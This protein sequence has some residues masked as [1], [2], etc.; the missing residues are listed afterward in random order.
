VSIQEKTFDNLISSIEKCKE[1][2]F[3][4]VLFS[5]GIRYIG[6]TTAKILAKAFGNI[7]NL[8]NATAEELLKVD[9]IGDKIAESVADFFSREKNLHLIEKL[10]LHGLSFELKSQSAPA[11]KLLEGVTFVVTGNFGTSEI[12]NNLKK[13]IE[14]YGGNVVSAVSKNVDF[15]LAG[16]K[17]G[18]EKI[19]KAGDLNIKV[20]SKEE[21]ENMLSPDP[22]SF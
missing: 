11:K 22:G 17:P 16:E 5:L 7:D 6:E 19:K 12:R 9:G 1:A 8:R 15:L 18:P 2:P 20:I 21:F 10:K 14:E 4:K 13:T 3:E